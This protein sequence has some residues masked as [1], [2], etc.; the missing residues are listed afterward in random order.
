MSKNIELEKGELKFP[1]Y[2]AKGDCSTC[3]K[4][5]Q[6]DTCNERM[7]FVCCSSEYQGDDKK[8]FRAV[9]TSSAFPDWYEPK[10]K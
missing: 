5:P 9:R 3:K 10:E 8:I 7:F 2:R 6:D 1:Y 4:T